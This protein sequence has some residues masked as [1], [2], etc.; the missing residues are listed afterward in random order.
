M[1]FTMDSQ[2]VTPWPIGYIVEFDNVLEELPDE[3]PEVL[4]PVE[5]VQEPAV[6]EAPPRVPQASEGGGGALMTV[7]IAFV[8]IAVIVAVAL[9]A[10]RR[11]N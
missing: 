10:R 2:D 11:Q 4:S 5:E 6:V 1:P 9:W 7:G 3:E 8:V